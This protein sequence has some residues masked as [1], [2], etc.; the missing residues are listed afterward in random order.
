M[1]ETKNRLTGYRQGVMIL[2]EVATLA[3]RNPDLSTP[4]VSFG[5]YEGDYIRYYC[6]NYGR[7]EE[8][9]RIVER[10]FNTITDH[11]G[12]ELEWIA[13]DPTQDREGGRHHRE[14]FILT[15]LVSGVRIEIYTQREAVGEKVGVSESGPDITAIGDGMVRAVTRS[16]TV[17]KPNIRLNALASNSL[18]LTGSSS[19]AGELEVLE[20]EEVY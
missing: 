2:R 8:R 9:Q 11:W 7:G 4:Q 10:E 3:E 14:Y 1:T 17:W 15:A 20:A 13:N 16:V 18:E 6:F 5:S 12:P 19:S